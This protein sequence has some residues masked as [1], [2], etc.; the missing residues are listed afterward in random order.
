MTEGAPRMKFA[1]I[2][3]INGGIRTPHLHLGN[4]IIMVEKERFKAILGEV[5]RNV[6]EHRVGA[7]EDYFSAIKPIV[8]A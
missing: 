4:E 8:G 1:A 2:K 6:T 7:E 5:A 3:G